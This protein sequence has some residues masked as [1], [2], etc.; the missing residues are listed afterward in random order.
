[1]YNLHLQPSECISTTLLTTMAPRTAVIATESWCRCGAEDG[2]AAAA[3][4][5]AVCCAMPVDLTMRY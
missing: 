2:V 3:I 5:W 1:M 4:S